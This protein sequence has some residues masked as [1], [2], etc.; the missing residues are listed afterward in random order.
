MCMLTRSATTTERVRL[1]SRT[2]FSLI[3]PALVPLAVTICEHRAAAF[4]YTMDGLP[5]PLRQYRPILA[6]LHRQE[7]QRRLVAPRKPLNL[8][9]IEQ[10]FRET[11]NS[12]SD[13]FFLPGSHGSNRVDSPL[14]RTRHEMVKGDTPRKRF[15]VTDLQD[16]QRSV[17][18]HDPWRAASTRGFQ[19]WIRIAALA[20][21]R[22]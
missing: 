14:A 15:E 3:P 12:P 11:S 5:K 20:L 21:P 22:R 10:P 16:D 9:G 19:C 17:L 1:I 7:R 18:F 13:R 6:P 8:L 2:D 4:P